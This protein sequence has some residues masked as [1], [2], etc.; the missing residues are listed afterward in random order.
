MTWSLLLPTV[1][2]PTSVI[3]H[4]LL[5]PNR[6]STVPDVS[7]T[8]QNVLRSLVQL[9]AYIHCRLDYRNSVLAGT[10]NIVIQRLQSIQ[11]TAARLIS[12]TTLQDHI[13]ILHSLHWL[14][15]WQK[16]IS[17]TLP[18]PV[19]TLRTTW[20]CPSVV[21]GCWCHLN[22][23][24]P[25]IQTSIGQP[26]VACYR[27]TVAER[28]SYKL[29]VMTYRSQHGKASQYLAWRT[30]ARQ[31]LCL[32]FPFDSVYSPSVVIRL[33]C[34]ETGWAHRPRPTGFFRRR[35]VCLEPLIG[36][37]PAV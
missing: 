33:S 26:S 28:I 2:L 9:Q 36:R 16:I 21:V 15:V 7:V 31:C 30:I 29:G 20:K 24:V 13:A 4:W 3:S 10:A 17:K 19:W 32:M 8:R 23:H 22:I 27:P 25:R 14:P 37:V 11:N 18:L 34:H 5:F 1:G 35:P 12:G 6:A